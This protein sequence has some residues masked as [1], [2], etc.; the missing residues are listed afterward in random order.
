MRQ[1]QLEYPQ[2]ELRPS[3]KIYREHNLATGEV[4][5]ERTG[6]TNPA[7]N[8]VQLLE[9][10]GDGASRTFTYGKHNRSNDG[11]CLPYPDPAVGGKLLAYTDF[12]GHTTNI[13]YE[14]D[15]T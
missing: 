3:H 13:G 6:G 15:G 10:R 14:E 9:N 4:G 11:T 12:L 5:T 2:G 7:P 1:F 8:T